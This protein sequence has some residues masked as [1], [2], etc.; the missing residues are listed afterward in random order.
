MAARCTAVETLK[1]LAMVA[2]LSKRN[3]FTTNGK[4]LQSKHKR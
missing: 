1:L 3:T 4:C 2:L